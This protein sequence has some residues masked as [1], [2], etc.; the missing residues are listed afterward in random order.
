MNEIGSKDFWRLRIGIGK[1]DDKDKVIQYVLGK[2]SK[3]DKDL[4]KKNIMLV[5]NEVDNFFDGK[6]SLLMTKLNSENKNNGI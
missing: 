3:S 4:I 1:P 2:P 6:S 5:L